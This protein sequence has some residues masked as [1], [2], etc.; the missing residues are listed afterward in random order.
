V[1]GSCEHDNEPSSSIKCWED[2]EQL[3]ASQEGLRSMKLFTQLLLSRSDKSVGVII[4]H[5]L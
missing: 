3:A 5:L 4:Y 1:E 2:L